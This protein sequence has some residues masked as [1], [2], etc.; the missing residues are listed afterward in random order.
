MFSVRSSMTESSK[1]PHQEFVKCRL[2]S[3][4]LSDTEWTRATLELAG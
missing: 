3:L 2:V 1:R 4:E